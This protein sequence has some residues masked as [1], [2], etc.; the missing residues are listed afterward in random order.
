VSGPAARRSIPWIVLLEPVVVAIAL[1]GLLVGAAAVGPGG[2][3][4][5]RRIE[6]EAPG[7]AP[8]VPC[9]TDGRC[10]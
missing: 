10:R 2:P 4:D 1:V 9:L 5:E 3:A 6:I 8:P 7:P